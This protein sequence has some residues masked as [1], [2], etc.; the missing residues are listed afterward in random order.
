MKRSFKQNLSLAI[1]SIIAISLALELLVRFVEPSDDVNAT[2]LFDTLI[3]PVDKGMWTNSPN[4]RRRFAQS[5]FDIAIR[6]NSQGLRDRE[7]PL[8]K[9]ANTFRILVLGDSFTF[10]YG[11]EAEETYAK[12]LEKLLNRGSTLKYEVLNGGVIGYGTFHELRFLR[13]SGLAL[14]PD[15]VVIGFV[16]GT[17]MGGPTG[18]DLF[19]NLHYK[20]GVEAVPAPPSPED[21][22]KA[23][24]ERHSHLYHFVRVRY[25]AMRATQPNKGTSI[26]ANTT[27]AN[28]YADDLERAW[29]IT[30]ELFREIRDLT[31]SKSIRTCVVFIP[32]YSNIITKEQAVSNALLA[33]GS[34]VDLPICNLLPILLQHMQSGNRLYF[35]K[36][37]GNHW[38]ARGHRVA[39]EAIYDCLTSQGL[40]AAE[41]GPN[42]M[43]QTAKK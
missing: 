24:L 34:E 37:P 9:P 6:T 25:W 11:V 17:D 26:D 30:R 14:H 38:N 43:S 36:D 22:V 33:V 5:E 41:T 35:L 39:A 40:V 18:S 27:Y 31:A 13:E 2:K 19:S 4:F 23:W 1:G 29:F 12:V 8:E 16:A 28:L 3:R 42:G 32:I 20:E 10:G 21:R 7:Y 15:L